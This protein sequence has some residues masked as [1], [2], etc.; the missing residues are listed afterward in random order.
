MSVEIVVHSEQETERLGAILA[1]ALPDGAVV[2]L[3]GTLGAGKTRLVQAVAEAS[4][5]PKGAVGSPTFVLVKEYRGQKREIYHFDAYRLRDSD[6][7][8]EL[9]VDEYFDS[10]GLSFVEW[11]DKVDDVIPLDHLEINVTLIDQLTRAFTLTACGEFEQDFPQRV[12][13][14]F[15]RDELTV[16]SGQA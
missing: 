12:K 7:F 11:A 2:T 1:H 14:A 16:N 13:N 8:L 3:L 9:G 6:E 4:G 10:N 5:V 15:E